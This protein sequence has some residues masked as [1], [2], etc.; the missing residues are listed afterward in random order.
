MLSMTKK[1]LQNN[2]DKSLNKTNIINDDNKLISVDTIVIKLVSPIKI[3]PNAD[4]QKMQILKENIG[5]SGVYLWKSN[6]N[7]KT[8]IGSS[9]DMSKRL[10]NYFN[11]SFLSF[12][13]VVI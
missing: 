7:G 13:F 10:K 8:Y 6:I 5:S 1:R 9:T 11:I 4:T 2:N 12:F 3:Y